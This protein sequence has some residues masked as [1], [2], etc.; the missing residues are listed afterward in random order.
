MLAAVAGLHDFRA[1]QPVAT[2][3]A[4]RRVFDDHGFATDMPNVWV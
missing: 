1:V 3:T 4:T 2:P